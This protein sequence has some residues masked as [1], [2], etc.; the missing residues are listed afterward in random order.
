M[1]LRV[2]VLAGALL[3]VPLLLAGQAHASNPQIAGLQVA[4]RAYGLYLQPVDG[5]AGPAT[6]E[7]T[8]AFQR[9]VGLTPDGIAGPR[10]RAALGPLGHPLFGRRHLVRGDFGWDVSVLQ[11]LLN[12]P[13]ID[14]YLGPTTERALRRWQRRARLVP[15]GIAGPATLTAFRT[16]TG[17]PLPLTPKR[18][19]IRRVVV[20]AENPAT[21]R[22]TLDHWAGHYGLDPSLARALAWMESGYNP[23]VTSSVGAW[24]VMQ[25]LPTTW[26][27]VE[28]S[29]IGRPVPRTAEG[30]V[31]VGTA[32]LHHLLNVFDGDETLALGAW[33]QGERAVRRNGLYPETKSFVANVLALKRRPL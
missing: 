27:Y 26:T 10:T 31:H 20:P 3:V 8:R 32:L 19:A 16:R 18:Q 6:R 15:D 28:T 5:I 25:I 4:L 21:V 30:N 12:M 1:R 29:L 2:L 9:R 23:N 33:Y 24:G 17:V 11:F 13:A 7:A 14:G 22:A